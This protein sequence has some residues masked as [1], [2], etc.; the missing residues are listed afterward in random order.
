MKTSRRHRCKKDF[1]LR[2]LVV[3][4]LPVVIKLFLT[5]VEVVVF[6]LNKHVIV[7]K[8]VL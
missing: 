2:G 5:K 8:A 4:G 6:Y 1:P 7:R 3:I